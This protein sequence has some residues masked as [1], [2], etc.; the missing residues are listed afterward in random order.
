MEN[1]LRDELRRSVEATGQFFGLHRNDPDGDNDKIPLFQEFTLSRLFLFFA[2]LAY[3]LSAQT[4]GTITGVISD[5][6]QAVMPGVQVKAL[7][8]ETRE[9]RS[10]T[11]NGQGA[12]AL[13]FLA[14]GN[15]RLEFSLAGFKT[16]VQRVTLNVTERI[17]VNMEM[18]PSAVA[19]SIEVK[20]DATQLQTETTTLGRVVDQTTVK[21]L[22]LSTRNFTQLLALSP[23]VN[24]QLNDAAALGRGTQNVSA[25]GARR[26]S[27]AMQI[28]GVDV[29]NI[30]TNSAAENTLSSN[31]VLVPSPEAIQEFKVQTGL[32]DAAHGRSGGANVNLVTRSGSANFHGSVFEFFRNEKLNANSFFFN[33]TGIRRPV[34]RQNQFG[35][36]VGGPVWKGKTFFFASYQGTRQTNGVSG[37]TSIRLPA[38]PTDRSRA[39]L[40]AA[41]SGRAGARGGVAVAANGSNINPVALALLNYK[42]ADGSFLIPSPQNESAGVNYAASIPATFSENQ[43]SL[44]AD[45]NVSGA[46]KLA[47]RMFFADQPQY[48]PFPLATVPGFG[49]T[50]AFRGGNYSLTDTHTFSGN[51]VNEARIGYSRLK[52]AVV[53]ETQVNVADI[54]MTRFNQA[55]IP[56]IPDLNVTG[57]FRLG[58]SVDADQ[59]GTQNTFHYTDTVSWIRGNHSF[60]F[61]GEAR[62]YQINYFN[63]NRQRGALAFQ[64]FPDFLLGLPGTPVAQGGNGTGFSNINSTSAANG[65]VG[66]ADRI[67]DLA[68]FVQD[69][70]KLT[71]RLTLN[72]GLRYDFLGFSVD[73]QG[74]NGN[75]DVR[76]YRPPPVGGS[77]SAG[78]VQASN[79]KRPLSGLPSVAPNLV[80]SDDKNNFAPRVGLAYRISN[81]TALRAGYGIFYDRLSNQ[82]GLRAALSAPNYIRSDLQAAA[83]INIDFRNPFPILPQRSDFPILPALFAPPYTAARPALSLNAIDGTLK[84][85]YM[86]HYT[87][88]LQHEL[89][90]TTLI[91]AGYVGTRGVSL[92][93]QRQINQALLASP[94]S[95]INGITTNTTGNVQDRVP[96]VGFSPTGLIWIETSTSSR[97][98]SLQLSVTQRVSRGLRFLGA[99]TWSKTLD[100]HSGDAS[101][102]LATV[103]GDQ[104]SLA[105][106]RGVASFDRTHRLVFNFVYDLP[107]PKPGMMRHIAGGWQVA[108]V[109]VAQSGLPFNITDSSAA[110]LYG[111]TTSR[112]TW[113]AG[114]T[115]DTANKS[116]R[117]QDRLNAY[118]NTAAFVRAGTGFGDVSRNALR[119][120]SQQNIDLSVN[121]R[122]QFLE[123]RYVEF[124]SEFFNL[125]NRVNFET[126]GSNV[127]TANNFGVITGTNGNPRI[128]QFALK[129]V[130]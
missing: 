83:A 25:S 82:L 22:P 124:R 65:N 129:L 75:F 91:E 77:T 95:P 103:D 89:F 130:F 28:D 2:L 61:G 105:L 35:G 7:N 6:T 4:T 99:Y 63:N 90:G 109:V 58:Y 46:N 56:D 24:A 48:R 80:D 69:D 78:F 92:P 18:T 47:F 66:R 97:Y 16:M 8:E 55:T 23:G 120:P 107:S 15:Y 32:F 114:A 116:G 111:V 93:A 51:L 67:T 81:Q 128:L 115:R 11:A 62:R 20:A 106:N 104:S 30:H 44:A 36:T 110:T 71:K 96:Y 127:S 52:G 112:A 123:R 38:I 42:K 41:F 86:Q 43:G 108:G 101:S 27:N 98:D 37:S 33:S 1:R 126:P 34:L 85:P 88:N 73:S 29:V 79:T 117:T 54:G 87:L 74:R 59:A 5:T 53:P 26:V 39:A 121:R 49:V 9:E 102:V 72:L 13:A 84:T 10:T 40:G 12:Y 50:Q 68:F 122:F 64:S 76:L 14:P 113:A 100:N 17:S 70:W 94:G 57:A 21:Q 3:S 45:H 31:G 19:E 60:R 118:F 119:G 125:T